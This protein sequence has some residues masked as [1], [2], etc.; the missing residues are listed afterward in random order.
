MSR[1]VGTWGYQGGIYKK[2]VIEIIGG[3]GLRD[4]GEVGILRVLLS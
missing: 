2:E 1:F 3:L 4:V